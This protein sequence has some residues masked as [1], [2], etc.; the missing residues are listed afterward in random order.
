MKRRKKILIVV[1]LMLPVGVGVLSFVLKKSPD[2]EN[3]KLPVLMRREVEETQDSY[4]APGSTETLLGSSTSTGQD[5]D[6]FRTIESLRISGPKTNSSRI[7]LSVFYI[8]SD[9]VYQKLIRPIDVDQMSEQRRAEFKN[10][11]YSL[12]ALRVREFGEEQDPCIIF[13][14][15]DSLGTGVPTLLFVSEIQDMTD[16]IVARISDQ[17]IEQVAAGNPP[18]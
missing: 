2:T 16:E 5:T 6:R 8:D 1:F 13:N 9:R 3:S 11:I 10:Q 18:G 12:I 4:S 7:E 15:A 17:H 14:S